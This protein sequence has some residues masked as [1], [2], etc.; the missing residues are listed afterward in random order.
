MMQLQSVIR[1]IYPSH[2]VAC[3]SE[4]EDDHGLCGTCWAKTHFIHGLVCDCC[5][6]P[7]PG[8][9]ASDDEKLKC[10][11]CMRTKR[12]WARGRAAM[13]YKDIGRRLVLALKHGD[14]TALTPSAARWMVQAARPLIQ[15]EM[16]VVP[17]PLH[18]SRMI[19]RRYN[20]AALLSGHV[21]GLTKLMH[22]PDALIR[23][24]RTKSLDGH[25]REE[26]FATLA[27]VIAP[28]PRRKHLIAGRSVL[29]IDDVMTTGATL[30]AC[31][32]ACLSAGAHQVCVLTLA[33]V[34]KDA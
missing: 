13:V 6:A 11:E 28:H 33:R 32:E 25:S 18:W 27:D 29:L 5:G 1:A 16:A 9:A 2:C 17:V 8:E 3:D 22:C 4:T 15:P 19:R 10:D 21:A 24:A 30:S 14:R 20:Q 12:P 23:T 26:R 34:V 31:A 7:L